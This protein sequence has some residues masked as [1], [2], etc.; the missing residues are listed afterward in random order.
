ME[1]IPNPVAPPFSSTI[2]PA[3][4]VPQPPP[5]VPAPIPPVVTNVF[6]AATSNP[7]ITVPVRTAEAAGFGDAKATNPTS[8]RTSGT[9]AAA[10]FGDAQG[11]RETTR[12]GAG[13]QVGAVGG[14]DVAAS[15][16]NGGERSRSGVMMAG[17]TSSSDAPRSTPSAQ[18]A[19]PAKL[20]KPVEILMKPRPDYTEE[21]RKLRIEGEVLLRVTFSASGAVRV[22]EVIRGLGHGLEENAIRAAGQIRFKPAERAGKPVDSTAVVHIAFQLAY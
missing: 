8:G 20:E 15:S 11:S 21:A 10:G 13:G 2:A 4:I 5:T 7:P 12:T 16:D 18:K 6:S 17:F 9:A 3:V 22:L 14:F 19:E 1:T